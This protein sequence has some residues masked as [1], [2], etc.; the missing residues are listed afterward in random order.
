VE[1]FYHSALED[2]R[3]MQ[4]SITD[5][6]NWLMEE[7]KHALDHIQSLFN[8]VKLGTDGKFDNPIRSLKFGYD[9]ISFMQQVSAFQ[10]NIIQLISALT[11]NI[12]IL[13]SMEANIL[14]MIQENLNAIASLLHDICNWGIPDL[15]AIPNL[16][17][18]NIWNW[19]GFNFFPLASFIPHPNFD[20]NFAFKQ[21]NIHLPNVNVLQNYP[22]TVNSYN[23][24]TY[25]APPIVP[26]L[27]GIIPNTGVNLSSGPFF[28]KMQTTTDV[29]YYTVDPSYTYPVTSGSP[30]V[31]EQVSGTFNPFTSMQG[32]LPDPNTIISDYQMPPQTYAANILSTIPGLLPDVTTQVPATLRKDLAR[33]VTLGQVVSSNFE[34]NL[35]A[36]WLY[37][38]S[39]ARNNPSGTGR[40]GQWLPSFDDAYQ[41]FVQPSVDYLST[42]PVPW[43]RVLP[44][45]TL[46]AGPTGL[47]FIIT[48]SPPSSPPV[49]TEEQGNALWKLSYV[50]AAMLGYIRNTTWDG[51]ADNNY[52]GTFTGTDL[53]YAMLNIV[54]TETTTIVLGEGL[55]TYPV[56]CTFP[57][58]LT[59]NL[60]QV[61]TTAAARIL[62]DTTYQS[63]Q[64]QYRYTYDQFAIATVVDRFSQFWR[65]FNGNLQALLV[66][67]PYLVGIVSAYPL[68]LDSAIDPL[69][70]LTIFSA[71]QVDT[72][73]RNRTWVPG[74]PLL[75]FSTVPVVVYTSNTTTTPAASGWTGTSFDP[76]AFLSRPDIQVLPIPVQAAMLQCNMSAASLMVYSTVIQ[77]EFDNAISLAQQQAQSASNFGFQVESVNDI[78][79]VLPNTVS[80]P[81]G[82]AVVSFDKIDFD[83][84]NYVTT[85]STF[86]IQAT[87][88][89]AVSGQI[90]FSGPGSPPIGGGEAGVRT[91]TV[92]L[93]PISGSPPSP[94]A[95]ITAS[96]PLQAG[97]VNLPFGDTVNLNEGDILT[98]IATHNLSDDQFV[99]AGSMFSS[100]L[101]Q[102]SPDVTPPVPP[103]PT[104]GGTLTLT[105]KVSMPALTAVF[106][107]QYG[108]VEP[109]DP[110][111]VNFN[112]SS[113]S[114]P[115]PYD[116]Y[117]F[118]D[119]VTLSSVT[120][121]QP[122]TI[123]TGYGSV[124]SVPAAGW[125]PGGLLYVGV[126]GVITQNFEGS[127]LQ[128]CQWVVVVGKALDSDTFAYEP[129]IPNRV[130]LSF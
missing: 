110:T 128:D 116:V 23:G 92:Y 77:G 10:R 15:P 9:I 88:A 74:F 41:T 54:K 4:K 13:Q 11:K 89:Y 127:V 65:E 55:A 38:V 53:D 79:D 81:G 16:F 26:P 58:A 96:T 19:N 82:G 106:V 115:F 112:P 43:N 21:C 42:T 64:P 20:F 125:T 85:T 40:Q 129:H 71:I 103:S 52:V 97:P 91:V 102:S 73:S 56:S 47:P 86:T 7:K 121:G 109:I 59:N 17:S 63:P 22:S 45:D 51:Y 118:V 114:P 32:S 36:A 67:D 111:T 105:A 90:N 24:L 29:P 113:L 93:T 98:V 27:G 122:V 84:T 44:G 30:P 119:G 14:A 61:I 49:P 99:I 48:L 80:P 95:I 101:Y 124:F 31:T 120:A 46:T 33:Y 5:A 126:G 87:G 3:E 6:N 70:D 50:E 8:H 78:T 62:L 72:A 66:Q 104:S 108:E 39:G 76:V 68:S 94:V 57:S 28:Q 18:D 34:P 1:T 69:G 83:Q 117:P 123:A 2:G 75:P 12:G 37:Y 107:D 130:M 60:Q 25:G 100:V 35:T